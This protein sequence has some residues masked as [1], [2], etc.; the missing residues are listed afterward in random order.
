MV[1]AAL[2]TVG[3]EVHVAVVR[4]VQDLDAPGVE[5]L[6]RRVTGYSNSFRD[7]LVG[8]FGVAAWELSSGSGRQAPGAEDLE[9]FE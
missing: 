7:Q 9:P 3:Q 2:A 5:D 8:E 4:P 1:S 6:L